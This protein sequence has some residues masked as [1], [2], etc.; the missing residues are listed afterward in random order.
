MFMTEG[1]GTLK[2]YCV[3]QGDGRP[4]GPV[5]I[6]SILLG[7]ICRESQGILSRA[8]HSHYSM[9]ELACTVIAGGYFILS[10]FRVVHDHVRERKYCSLLWAGPWVWVPQHLASH[11]FRPKGGR[12]GGGELFG[13]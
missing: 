2:F 13:L 9:L 8:I 10:S 3:I 4:Q 7:C 6:Q 11:V 5:T 1:G 12:G